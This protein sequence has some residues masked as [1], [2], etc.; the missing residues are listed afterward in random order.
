MVPEALA[1]QAVPGGPD[2]LWA[3]PQGDPELLAILAVLAAPEDPRIPSLL[4]I[5]EF[6]GSQLILGNP[7]HPLSLSLL[8]TLETLGCL[9]R[10]YLVHPS[11]LPTLEIHH[12]RVPLLGQVGP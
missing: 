11:L 4:W 8:W 1:G 9:F 5:Q 2:L 3:P 6:L 12:C 7:L 10:E